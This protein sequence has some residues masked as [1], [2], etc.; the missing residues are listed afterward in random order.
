MV[1]PSHNGKSNNHKWLNITK[2]GS[3]GVFY[4]SLLIIVVI[5]IVFV[6]VPSMSECVSFL[7]FLAERFWYGV[8]CLDA[9]RMRD[10]RRSF[11]IE[12]VGAYA[13][14]TTTMR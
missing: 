1:D 2:G 9:R 5:V 10:T 12:G 6:I 11:M 7:L 14:I 4:I 8:E 3:R 13:D